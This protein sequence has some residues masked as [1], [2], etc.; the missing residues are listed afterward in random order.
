MLP[1]LLG[2]E[3]M[4]VVPMIDGWNGRKGVLNKVYLKGCAE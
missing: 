3:D 4:A 2:V 1:F